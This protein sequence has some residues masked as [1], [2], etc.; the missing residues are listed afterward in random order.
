MFKWT[1]RRPSGEPS[2]PKLGNV[3]LPDATPETRSK[4][5]KK[6]QTVPR[7]SSAAPSA[8]QEHRTKDR[9]PSTSSTLK[10]SRGRTSSA[11]KRSDDKPKLDSPEVQNDRGEAGYHSSRES[12]R[13]RTAS[14]SSKPLKGIL[15]APKPFDEQDP[16]QPEIFVPPAPEGWPANWEELGRRGEFHPSMVKE[17][18][19]VNEKTVENTSQNA[20]SMY[21]PLN[22]PVIP[23][24]TYG[25][26]RP[27]I[28]SGYPAHGPVIPDMSKYYQGN[29]PLH[30]PGWPGPPLHHPQHAPAHYP[31]H[32]GYQGGNPDNEGMSRTRSNGGGY[33]SDNEGLSRSYSG[34]YGGVAPQDLQR[35]MH[36]AAQ[37]Q[38]MAHDHTG[39]PRAGTYPTYPAPPSEAMIDAGRSRN[40]SFSTPAPEIQQYEPLVPGTYLAPY[41]IHGTEP[42]KEEHIA[43]S[44]PLLEYAKRKRQRKPRLYFDL[45]F[46]PRERNTRYGIRV[47]DIIDPNVLGQCGPLRH[48]REDELNMSVSSHCDLT[49]MTIVCMERG[50]DRWPVV[51]RRPEG[52]IRCI[53]VFAAIYDTFHVTLTPGE[54]DVLAEPVRNAYGTFLQ[55]CKDSPGNE[56]QEQLRGMCRIDLLRSMKIFQGITR[57]NG[58]W[59]LE[60][61]RPQ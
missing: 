34:K 26:S 44:W 38:A 25:P 18:R 48:P 37:Q 42:Q 19:Y 22:G 51:V 55:R 6:T 8:M 16:N 61:A 57:R 60:V 31:R 17:G 50:L 56:R 11:I 43:L 10:P 15:K 2:T 32:R 49:E 58:V 24:L 1:R 47:Q 40:Y 30:Y 23:P 39:R 12:H 3:S 9:Y 5:L 41:V 4:T 20:A 54:I 45:A 7:P 59:V 35:A 36:Y 53:D 29:P 46:D 21:R 14:K 28:P 52:A 33:M 13:P 27:S